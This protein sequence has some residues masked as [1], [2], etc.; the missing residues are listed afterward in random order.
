MQRLRIIGAHCSGSH[1]IDCVHQR[2]ICVIGARIEPGVAKVGVRKVTARRRRRAVAARATV[3]IDRAI[4]ERRAHVR[5]VVA[6]RVATNT[7]S[8]RR[9]IGISSALVVRA[10]AWPDQALERKATTVRASAT[11]RVRATSDVA[12]DLSGEAIGIRLPA[13][14]RAALRRATRR[15][16]VFERSL[17]VGQRRRSS[18][19]DW[20]VAGHGRIVTGRTTPER[21]ACVVGATCTAAATKA[22]NGKQRGHRQREV[23]FHR[24]TLRLQKTSPLKRLENGASEPRCASQHCK[25]EHTD[26]HHSIKVYYPYGFTHTGSVG[27]NS[28]IHGR[29]R[30]SLNGRGRRRHAG[31]ALRR[32]L[33]RG[34]RRRCAFRWRANGGFRFHG[35]CDL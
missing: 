24:D 12:V 23:G 20:R 14:P 4:A 10:S 31:R 18:I 21:A 28:E 19:A 30:G 15:G 32:M 29:S 22:R 3:G 7:G 17:A 1:R 6:R 5:I 13:G 11:I 34:C 35:R 33:L 8:P 9:T 16:A 26:A 27:L 25:L 2:A